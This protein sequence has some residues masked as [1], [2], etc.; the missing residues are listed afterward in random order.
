METNTNQKHLKVFGIP[1][2]LPFLKNV[3]GQILM[4]VLLAIISSFVDITIPQ[5]QRYALDT[6]GNTRE[7]PNWVTQTISEMNFM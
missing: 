5:F 6:V 3:R 2:I 1:E 7:T 4:M